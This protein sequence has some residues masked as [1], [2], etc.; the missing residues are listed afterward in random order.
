MVKQIV[1]TPQAE[2]T[3]A[4]VVDYLEK[5]WTEKEIYKLFYSLNSTI[6]LIKLQPKLFRCISKKHHIH[7]ALITKHNLMIYKIHKNSV[8]IITFWDTRKHPKTKQQ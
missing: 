6:D 2:K 7:E 4:Q 1:W 8:V 3:L 5:E